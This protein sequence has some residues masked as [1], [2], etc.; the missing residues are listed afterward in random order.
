MKV[1]KVLFN[2]TVNNRNYKKD[3][4]FL[5]TSVVVNITHNFSL[6][7]TLALDKKTLDIETV[8]NNVLTT[9]SARNIEFYVLIGGEYI[10]IAISIFYYLLK[11]NVNYVLQDVMIEEE[12][13]DFVL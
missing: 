4:R 11:L 2:I 9:Q 7:I 1:I 13:C 5:H 6:Y 3:I 10:Q 8:Y 12:R